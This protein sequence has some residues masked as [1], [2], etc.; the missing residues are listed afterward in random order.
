MA[1]SKLGLERF[2]VDAEVST[3]TTDVA[4]VDFGVLAFVCGNRV[5]ARAGSTK[6]VLMLPARCAFD[7]E[8]TR[9]SF[10]VS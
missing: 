3:K 7:I 8:P 5:G 9:G 2:L 4:V 1:P 10:D 6:D